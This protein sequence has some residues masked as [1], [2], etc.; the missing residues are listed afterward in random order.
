MR[1]ITLAVA[2]GESVAVIGQ[3]GAGKTTMSKMINGLLKPSTGTVRVD[4]VDTRER[5]AAQTARVVGYVFQNPDDQIFHSTVA[6][7][8]SYGLKRLKLDPE[9]SRRRVEE[10]ATLCGLAGSL[11]ENPYDLP[12]SVRKFVTIALVIALDPPVLI[13]DEP[14]AGQD[15]AGLERIAAIVGEM[16]GRGKAVLTITHDMEFVAEN[17]ARVV[18]MAKGQVVTDGPA[19]RIF[20]DHEALAAARLNQPVLA[21]LASALG[22]EQVG[23]G[24]DALAEWVLARRR[25]AGGSTTRLR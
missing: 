10:A 20:Y 7:E 9:E 24:A 18:V 19:E 11:E 14:T 6:G 4:G 22:A 8:I 16:S 17:V 13:L 5:T 21:E 15:L 23:L 25:G 12:L 3:N 1:G 2:D